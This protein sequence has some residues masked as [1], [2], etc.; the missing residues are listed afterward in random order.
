MSTRRSVRYWIGAAIA[1]LIATAPLAAQTGSVTGEVRTS[2]GQPLSGAQVQVVGTSLGSLTQADG[3]FLIRGVPV[4]EQEV[5]VVQL[6]YRDA[7][8]SV[9]VTEGGTAIANFTMNVEAIGL[10][11]SLIHI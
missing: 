11:L 5:R 7:R 6:G 10:D 2:E 1:M 9:Q 3:R 4:G 8:R